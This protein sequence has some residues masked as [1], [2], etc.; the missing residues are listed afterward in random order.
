MLRLIPNLYCRLNHNNILKIKRNNSTIQKDELNIN[1]I[2]ELRN[3]LKRSE[4]AIIDIKKSIADRASE[5]F[6]FRCSLVT[7][8]SL[9]LLGCFFKSKVNKIMNK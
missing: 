7:F 9:G 2:Q 4:K 5:R 6:N 8:I 3:N 1:K